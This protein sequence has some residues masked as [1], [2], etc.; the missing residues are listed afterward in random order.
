M[1]SSK[2]P[3]YDNINVWDS[4]P[5]GSMAESQRTE[6]QGTCNDVSRTWCSHRPDRRAE[7]PWDYGCTGSRKVCSVLKVLSRALAVQD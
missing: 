4:D 2:S 5:N 6:L 3:G 7:K 1:D